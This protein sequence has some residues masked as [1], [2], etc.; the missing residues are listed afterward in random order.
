M[1]K[2]YCVSC[3]DKIKNPKSNYLARGNYCRKC[4]GLSKE[5]VDLGL[6]QSGGMLKTLKLVHD[7]G[8]SL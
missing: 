3:G 5:R 2:N 8:A 4:S 1:I 6:V 7:S